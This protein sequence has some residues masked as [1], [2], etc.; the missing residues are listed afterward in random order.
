MHGETRA[1]ASDDGE[2]AEARF[3]LPFNSLQ[4]QTGRRFPRVGI[5]AVAVVCDRDL[6]RSLRA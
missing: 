4:A 6:E 5:I 1:A 3:E 2:L